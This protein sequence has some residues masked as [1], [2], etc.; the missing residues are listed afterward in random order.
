M[1]S[2]V[3]VMKKQYL[4]II[5][6]LTL[7]LLTGCTRH[8]SQTIV[9]KIDNRPLSLED[10][11]STYARLNGG[12]E[13]GQQASLE[14]REEFL[15]LLVKFKLKIQDAYDSGLHREPDI[16]AELEEYQRSLAAAFLVE[17][18]LVEPALREM[19]RRRT[20]EIRASHILIRVPPNPE[21]TDT[22]LAYRKAMEVIQK[23]EEGED[24][25]DLSQQYSEDPGARNNQGDLYYFS[26]GMMVKP[27][28]DAAFGLEVGEFT[29]EPVRTQ[30]GYHIIKLT[31]RQP[32]AG[33]VRVSH[34]MKFAQRGMSPEDTL[35][36]YNTINEILDSLKTGS[37]FEALAFE[38][39]EDRQ[40]AE[41][42][43]DLGMI[44]RRSLPPEFE[45]VAFS[46]QP[47]EISDIVRTEYGFHIIKVTDIQPMQSF[48]EMKD[49]LR[50]Q[51]QQRYMQEDY[52]KFLSSLKLN[53]SF[54][55]QDENIEKFIAAVDTQLYADTPAWHDSLAESHG[56]LALFD[57]DGET[58]TAER[59]ARQ[60]Q[61][62]P[63]FTG[64]RLVPNNVRDMVDRIG[65][66]KLIHR[67][68]ENIEERYPEFAENISE[69]HEG[70]LIYYI[71]Q[72]RVWENIDLSEDLLLEFYEENQESYTFPDRVNICE[73]VVRSDSLAQV[74]YEKI[75]AGE[76]MEE[77]AAGH[78]VRSGMRRQRGVTGMIN[79]DRDELSLR[80]FAQEVGE[81]SK[82]FQFGNNYA[83]VKTLE[84][85]AARLRT[86]DEARAQV[87][88]EY[89]DMMAKKIEREWVENLKAR[90]RV[91][92]FPENLEQAFVREE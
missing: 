14:E 9:A 59:V 51:Y 52:E 92:V 74:V 33:S 79:A 21:P 25:A 55:R 23:L 83:L 11:E 2:D 50:R 73:I 80:G 46:L 12:W 16:Q 32:A 35:N 54:K 64:R 8:H 85:E 57:I 67:E 43:G 66:I 20:E 81:V 77:L 91:A 44:R 17:R 19:Y 26:G 29:R 39:S 36:A 15:D 61:N 63:E 68:A 40:S 86:F 37:E 42:F 18:E 70:I 88:G 28:E 31:G 47:G 45:N 3:S 75:I 4:I 38:Y 1:R 89:Q 82:P 7:I 56:D 84:R 87:T 53:Y 30:F 60:I 13:R 76:D 6:L 49:N 62:N 5:P 71:E 58:I 27:F 10:Y 41:R 90:Y 65:E 22:M 48:E 69:Y 24:F 72:K 78:T 34:I